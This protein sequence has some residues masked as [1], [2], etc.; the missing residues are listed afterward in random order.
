MPCQTID[1]PTAEELWDLKKNS[2]ELWRYTWNLQFDVPFYNKKVLK[3]SGGGVLV[4]VNHPDYPWSDQHCIS[5]KNYIE[6]W[7]TNRPTTRS[8]TDIQLPPPRTPSKQKKGKRVKVEETGDLDLDLSLLP[9]SEFGDST[10]E[11]KK[12]IVLTTPPGSL[13]I[14]GSLSLSTPAPVIMTTVV[15]RGPSIATPTPFNG[16]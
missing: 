16:D 13:L 6:S 5:L 3:Y 7:Q 15:N 1:C 12:P 10:S 11:E 9:G 2:L 8:N 14:S 4:T